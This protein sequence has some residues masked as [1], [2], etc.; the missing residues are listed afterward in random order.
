MWQEDFPS[1]ANK[2]RDMVRYGYELVMGT[3]TAIAS[4]VEY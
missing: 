4:F 1:D 3:R 2:G